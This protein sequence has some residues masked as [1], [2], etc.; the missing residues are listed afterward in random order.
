MN[1]ISVALTVIACLIYIGGFI[2]GLAI[3]EDPEYIFAIWA[4]T[5]ISGTMMLSFAE[6][7]KLLHNIN[8]K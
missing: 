3:G 7:I 6:I 8:K 4:V 5:G 2:A 1:P